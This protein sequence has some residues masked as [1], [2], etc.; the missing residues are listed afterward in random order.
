[1]RLHEKSAKKRYLPEGA[2][3]FSS[4]A[5]CMMRV[6]YEL[7][8]MSKLLRLDPTLVL[9]LRLSFKLLRLEP[10]MLSLRLLRLEPAKL[11]LRLLRLDPFKLSFKLFLF[12]K[13]P[14]G[15]GKFFCRVACKTFSSTRRIS[16]HLNVWYI[17]FLTGRP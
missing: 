9:L 13:L 14:C 11:S 17:F 10:L 15:N 4:L 16:V 1:M 6:L 8:E 7:V 5:L 2:H 3:E 12:I